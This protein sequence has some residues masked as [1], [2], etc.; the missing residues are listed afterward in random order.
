MKRDKEYPTGMF[1]K[2]FRWYCHPNMRDYIEGDL[3]EVYK[4][5]LRKSGKRHA[6][7]MFVIDV[8]LLFRPG[9]IRPREENK[10]LI[11]NGMLRNYIKIGWRNLSR[12]KG[13]T[14]INVAGLTLS[15]TCGIFIFSLIK[16]HLSFDDFHPNTNHTYR[17]VTE[18]HRDGVAYRDAVP[19]PLGQFVRNDFSFSE[20]IAR[21]Y[22]ED[23]FLI[24]IKNGNDL[25]KFTEPG[26]VSF[27]ES[28]YFDIFNF[29]LVHGSKASFTE[30]NTSF[31]TERVAK[32]FFGDKDPIGQVFWVDN[33]HAFTITGILKD[34]PSNTDLN[35]EVFVSWASLKSYD[36]WMA[37]DTRGWNGIREGMRCYIVLQ[38]GTS[39]AEVESVMQPYVKRFRPT[40]KNVHHYKLQP[41]NDIHFNAQYGGS[42]EKKKLWALSLIGVFLIVTACVNFVN[43]ATAQALRRS[44][45]VGVRK[46]L[47]SLKRQLFWQFI[48]ETGIITLLAIV[49]SVILAMALIPYVGQF[50]GTEIPADIFADWY[51][52]PFIVGLGVF[53]TLLAGYYPGLVIS[54][55]QPVV[56]LK[57]KLSQRNIGGFNMRRTL[58][59]AQFALSQILIIGMIVIMDQMKFAQADLGFERDG[60]VMIYTGEDSTDTKMNTLKNEFARLQSVEKISLCFAAPASENDWGNSIRFENDPEEVN[61]RTSIKAADPDYLSTFDL[62]LV[63][64]RNLTPSDTVREMLIN[65]TM[66]HKLNLKSPEDAIGKIII[67]NGGSMKAPI[68][69][70][71]KDFHDKSFHEDISA[72]LIT[73]YVEDYSFYAV[74][75]NMKNAS[76]TL[77]ELERLWIEQHP[78]QLFRYEFVDD[79]ITRFYHAEEVMLN[80][81]RF[82]SFVAIFIGSLGLYGLVSFMVGQKTK[83]IGI[84]K[85]LG[86]GVGNIAGVFGKEF[87]YLI[88]VAFLIAAPVAWWLMYHWLQD[89]KFQ[90]PIDV[91]TFVPALFCS[92]LVAAVTVSYQVMKA[93]FANP[94]NSLGTE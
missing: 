73:T 41:L 63:A 92:F 16:H 80:L 2:F 89:Y 26:G 49:T 69:G 60:V 29:P 65:E 57:G 31:V 13:Y 74:K 94:V 8:L 45:E 70:V 19:A 83:E 23:E 14:A 84:R 76:A 30:A 36:P 18:L 67:A 24:T 37:D 78:D 91:W 75:M 4:R 38:P 34:L 25:K 11:M 6:D 51:L 1:L 79:S 15:I 50:F 20:K 58:I 54:G 27:T 53:I 66:V 55:F 52:I 86:A 28:A 82:F 39:T 7:L 17:I 32:K 9:I 21:I 33:A 48:F 47:G 90:T 85:I 59:V 43:L 42:F 62:E 61:F 81:I 3:F 10:N 56:A 72:I 68:V 12:T 87:S 44:K 71:L 88:A 35:A 93:A 40:S 77:A 22:T 5:R 64:G 46:V